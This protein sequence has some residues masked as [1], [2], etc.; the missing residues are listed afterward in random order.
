[1]AEVLSDD[2]LSV[3]EDVRCGKRIRDTMSDGSDSDV[4]VKKKRA[5]TRRRARPVAITSK[6]VCS[7]YK[8]SDDLLRF[9]PPDKLKI[10][11]LGDS[12][13]EDYN[14][15]LSRN[16]K[17]KKRKK[18]KKDMSIVLSSNENSENELECIGVTTEKEKRL[19]DVS[20]D[21]PSPPPSPPLYAQ[22]MEQPVRNKKDMKVIKN[23]NAA[24]NSMHEYSHSFQ[25]PFSGADD[26][27]TLASPTIEEKTIKVKVKCKCGL[28]RYDLKMTD[29]FGIVIKTLADLF[30]VPIERIALTL[31]N[32]SIIATDTPRSVN[33]HIADF[34]ECVVLEPGSVTQNS[35]LNQ[36]ENCIDIKIQSKGAKTK[37][38][39]SI[40]KTSP[41]QKLMDDYAKLI[42]T[43]RNNITFYFDGD[44]IT[45]NQ[46]PADIDI[47]SDDV[48]DAVITR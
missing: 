3:V 35:P 22:F 24:L 37:K 29:S 6:S 20:T 8:V 40:K 14:L 26:S 18:K 32:D 34:I 25:S 1:M 45:P 21:S 9:K 7:I 19:N 27:F 31:R 2:D 11:E 5:A 44:K 4:P 42:D 39:V 17:E 23:V 33:L 48:I 43:P 15:I 46:T 13:D 47:E 28:Q 36:K 38:T 16:P 41:L 10:T 30:H 12:D